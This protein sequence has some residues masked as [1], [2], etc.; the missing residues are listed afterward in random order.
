MQT[1]LEV[2]GGYGW[3]GGCE[4]RGGERR[5]AEVRWRWGEVGEVMGTQEI[6]Q[7]ARSVHFTV[8]SHMA[9]TMQNRSIHALFYI[10]GSVAR[11][12]ELWNSSIGRA[13]QCEQEPLRAPNSFDYAKPARAD[14]GSCNQTRHEDHKKKIRTDISGGG[15]LQQSATI[16]VLYSSRE[17]IFHTAIFQYTKF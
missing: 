11:N 13:P 8:D 12:Q 6:T 9:R 4:G 2:R 7:C 17:P 5:W 16:H 3:W 14:S 10:I 1:R 15:W